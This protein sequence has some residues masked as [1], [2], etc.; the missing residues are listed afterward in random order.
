MYI[1]SVIMLSESTGHRL[2]WLGI[3]LLGLAAI[4][5]IWKSF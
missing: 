4:L 2:F 5:S 3:G 1:Q